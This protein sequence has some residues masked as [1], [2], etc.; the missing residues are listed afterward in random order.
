MYL[1]GIVFCIVMIVVIVVLLVSL[2][3]DDA[4]ASNKRSRVIEICEQLIELSEGKH[5]ASELRDIVI[6]M[7]KLGKEGDFLA[8]KVSAIRRNTPRTIPSGYE[9]EVNA[10]VRSLVLLTLLH[11]K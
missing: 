10:K 9:N 4:R 11:L 3:R 6:L 5:T 1:W 8:K 2:C 7:E